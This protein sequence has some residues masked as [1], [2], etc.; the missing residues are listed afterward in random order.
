MSFL[1]VMIKRSRGKKQQDET[2]KQQH[3]IVTENHLFKNFTAECIR[4]Y[5]QKQ[6]CKLDSY[7]AWNFSRC[8]RFLAGRSAALFTVTVKLVGLLFVVISYTFCSKTFKQNV[9][10]HNKM[11]LFLCFFISLFSSASFKHN[12]Q[13][14]HFRRYIPM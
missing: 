11:L 7:I 14:R 10:C 6:F 12:L 13:R 1:Q 9:F 8:R 2:E 5:D 3:V 4:N